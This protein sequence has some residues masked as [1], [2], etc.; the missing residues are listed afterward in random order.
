MRAATV[1]ELDSSSPSEASA[2]QLAVNETHGT[3]LCAGCARCSAKRTAS[4]NTVTLR[5]EPRV[6]HRYRDRAHHS[7]RLLRASLRPAYTSHSLRGC[8]LALWGN[9][10]LCGG[11]RC[12]HRRCN[13]VEY[14]SADTSSRE[15]TCL[16]HKVSRYSWRENE[17]IEWIDICTTR[18]HTLRD[19][20]A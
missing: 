19:Y 15:G 12:I 16:S 9:D 6:C 2:Q 11:S 7:V 18:D 17:C 3:V 1:W 20:E 13:R 8:G 4:P 14:D 10:W 5:P